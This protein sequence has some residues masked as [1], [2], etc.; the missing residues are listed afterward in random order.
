MPDDKNTGFSPG[1]ASLI[2]QIRQ[3]LIQAR[4][5]LFDANPISRGL[6][7]VPVRTARRPP[8]YRVK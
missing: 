5:F 7:P 8:L 6:V 1:A 4:T 3:K 2:Q